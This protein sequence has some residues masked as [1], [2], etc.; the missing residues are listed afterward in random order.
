[1]TSDGLYVRIWEFVIKPE[2]RAEFE[3]FYGPGGEWVLL[4]RRSKAFLRTEFFRDRQS[5]N[6]YVTIDY[7]SSKAGFDDFLREFRQEY[8]ALD[9]RCDGVIGSE[10]EIGAFTALGG[11]VLRAGA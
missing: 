11:S 7:F 1:M 4:F 9:R 10:K 2:F 6:R 8:E 5:E 3:N